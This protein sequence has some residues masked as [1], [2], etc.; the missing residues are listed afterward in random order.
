M[1]TSLKWPPIGYIHMAVA[2]AVEFM[3][4][5]VDAAVEFQRFQPKFIA[6]R[7]IERRRRLYPGAIE[8]NSA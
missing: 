7:N 5:G 6:K 2:G 8:P 1:G 4:Q 3:E